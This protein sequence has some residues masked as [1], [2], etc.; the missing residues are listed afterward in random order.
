LKIGSAK[1]AVDQAND[2]SGFLD[3]ISVGASIA[4]RLRVEFRIVRQGVVRIDIA[5]AVDAPLEEGV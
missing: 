2:L 3:R 4:S 1:N 5:T